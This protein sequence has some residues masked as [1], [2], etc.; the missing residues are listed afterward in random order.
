MLSINEDWFIK[1]K[2]YVIKFFYDMLPLV[3]IINGKEKLN[4]QFNN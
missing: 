4:F 2:L 3:K 1:T